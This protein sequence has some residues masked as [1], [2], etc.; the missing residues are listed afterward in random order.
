[1]LGMFLTRYEESCLDRMIV[2]NRALC[3]SHFG[4]LNDSL[5][6]LFSESHNSV[7][8]KFPCNYCDHKAYSKSQK[9]EHERAVHEGA[10]TRCPVCDAIM[11]Y[12]SN[13]DQH[14]KA[15]H[16]TRSYPC[17][18]CDVVSKSSILLNRHKRD[19]H[20]EKIYQCEIC[21]FKASVI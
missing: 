21:D 1:M 4:C 10:V 7:K 12:S 13:L 9:L 2:G 18:E 6:F 19:H 17:D 8:M 5:P 3:N 14:I 16:G 15:M 11:K 20:R